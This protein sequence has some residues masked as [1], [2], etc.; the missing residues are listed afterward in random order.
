MCI[1]EKPSDYITTNLIFGTPS[2][3]IFFL[4]FTSIKKIFLQ[5]LVEIIFKYHKKLFLDFWDP[6]GWVIG[7][8]PEEIFGNIQ[9]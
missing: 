5:N 7:V 6:L 8:N 3:K 1:N 9:N 4:F 2:T